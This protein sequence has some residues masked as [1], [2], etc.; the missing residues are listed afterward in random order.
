MERNK[1]KQRSAITLTKPTRGFYKMPNTLNSDSFTVVEKA[2][3][4]SLMYHRNQRTKEC[5]PTHAQIAEEN[6]LSVS[7]VKRA[8]H[9]LN[10]K[11][12]VRWDGDFWDRKAYEGFLRLKAKGKVDESDIEYGEVLK[13]KLKRREGTANFYRLL[14]PEHKVCGYAVETEPPARKEPTVEQPPPTAPFFNGRHIT[15][16]NDA[17]RKYCGAHCITKDKLHLYLEDIDKY[18][19]RHPERKK[20]DYSAFIMRWIDRNEMDRAIMPITEPQKENNKSDISALLEE[21]RRRRA[22]G[23]RSEAEKETEKRRREKATAHAKA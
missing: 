1:E 5:Y 16:T 17:A 13:R 6:G 10:L 8:L 20:S 19:T 9:T 23:E 4:G 21:L 12:A 15:I 7:T 22:T 18:L 2:V 14:L 3:Y 11:H